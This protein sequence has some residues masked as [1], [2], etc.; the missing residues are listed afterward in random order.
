VCVKPIAAWQS[1]AGGIFFYEDNRKDLVRRLD[2]PCGQCI[3]CRLNRSR[4]WAIRCMHEASLYDKNSFVTL[5]YA[6]ERSPPNGSLRHRDFQLFFKRLRRRLSRD[7]TRAIRF[8]MCGEYGP[9]TLR[10]HFHALLFGYRPDDLVY[11]R[12]SRQG[13]LYTS[14]FLEE[15]WG[16]GFVTVGD[17]TFESASYVSRYITDKITGPERELA[18]GSYCDL[19]TGE[20]VVRAPEYNQMSRRP[21]IGHSWLRLYWSEV[22][23]SG[24]VVS[25]GREVAPPKYYKKV[26]RHLSAFE[27]ASYS[28]HKH[29]QA[30]ASDNTDDRLAVREKVLKARLSLSKKD[31]I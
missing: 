10:P 21:G 2:L 5:T 13:K 17:V 8:Y 28:W 11:Y 27:D 7:A 3:E 12:K 16:N 26:A 31:S 4:E 23:P 24:T 15:V 20:I 19:E 25:R 1:S 18:Y 22:F 30:R 6:P 14:A 9:A 29:A